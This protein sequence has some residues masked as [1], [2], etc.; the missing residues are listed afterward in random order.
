[1]GEFELCVR[2]DDLYV[3]GR[4]PEGVVQR[5]DADSS[6]TV[7][8]LSLDT[9]RRV[10]ETPN[11]LNEALVC[12]VLEFA[13][14]RGVREVS[15]NY[16]G[17]GTPG[18]SGPSG[19]WLSRALAARARSPLRARFQMDRLV[20][21]NEKF[22]PDWRPRYLVYESRRALPRT[23]LRVLQAEGYVPQ[24]RAGRH[25]RGFEPWRASASSTRIEG[26]VSR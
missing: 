23:V 2:P 9:M 24:R 22:S 17:L 8:S 18:S 20:L 3:L 15:L 13:R 11:G 12:A 7:G 26:G 14:E 10:G 16:A 1:M 4:S 21:F 6:H 5:R 25:A 19:N